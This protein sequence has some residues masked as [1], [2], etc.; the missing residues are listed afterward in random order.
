MLCPIW[1]CSRNGQ[2]LEA[3]GVVAPGVDM[4]PPQYMLA[5]LPASRVLDPPEDSRQYSSVWN[6]D[7]IGTGHARSTLGSAQVRHFPAQFPPF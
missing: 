7:A 3:Y 1:G 4:T 5:Q 6:N 2:P